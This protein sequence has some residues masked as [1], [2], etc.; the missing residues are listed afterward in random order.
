[1]GEWCCTTTHS[2]PVPSWFDAT[3][4][5]PESECSVKMKTKRAVRAHT[6]QLYEERARCYHLFTPEVRISDERVETT[7]AATSTT[8]EVGDIETANRVGNVREGAAYEGADRQGEAPWKHHAYQ[9]CRLQAAHRVELHSKQL[10]DAWQ[11]F[12]GRKFTCA[13]MR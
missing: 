11:E 13:D 9:G 6:K 8:T 12:L 10:L 3:H 7:I 1:M 2:P 5:F 4:V